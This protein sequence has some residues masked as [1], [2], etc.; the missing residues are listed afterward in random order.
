VSNREPKLLVLSDGYYPA[1]WQAYVDGKPVRTYQANHAFRAVCV[2]AGAKTVEFKYTSKAYRNGWIISIVTL[3][4]CL[5]T[6]AIPERR[7]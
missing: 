7:R 6:V 4:I 3:L 2:P 5:A 1:G